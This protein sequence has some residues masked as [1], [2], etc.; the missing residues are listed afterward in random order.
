MEVLNSG[1]NIRPKDVTSTGDIAA[2]QY[3]GGTTGKAKGAMLT[4][5]NIIT[6]VEMV[7]EW[8]KLREKEDT[9]LIVLP[10]FHIFGFIGQMIM[11]K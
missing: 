2:L 5:K 10:L 4:H 11:K 8:V 1:D 7:C 3:T 6:E 9:A